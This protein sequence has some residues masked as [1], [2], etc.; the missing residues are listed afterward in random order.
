MT[1]SPALKVSRLAVKSLP[2]CFLLIATSLSSVVKP[3]CHA[4]PSRRTWVSVS[5]S[6]VFLVNASK[7][8]VA[9]AFSGNS[10]LKPTFASSASKSRL[11]GELTFACHHAL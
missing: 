5:N 1:L 10:K 4:A 7:L 2:T 6:P 9:L 8:G 11:A 3:P